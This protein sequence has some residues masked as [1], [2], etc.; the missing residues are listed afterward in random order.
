MKYKLA[1]TALALIASPS[2]F[3]QTCPDGVTYN[4]D[5]S[6][7]DSNTVTDGS[8]IFPVGGSGISNGS[9]AVC[10]HPGVQ[11]AGRIS[12]RFVGPITPT[13][14][15]ADYPSPAGDPN[16]DGRAAWNIEGHIDFG[17]AIGDG[18]TPPEMLGDVNLTV[19]VDCDPATD[20][21]DG[22]TLPLDLV[23]DT[24]V[25]LQFSQNIG[26]G[27]LCENYGAGFDPDA[28]GHYSFVLTLLEE[29][30]PSTTVLASLQ[31]NAIVGNP[32][33]APKISAVGIIESQQD[34]FKFPDGTVQTTA[35]V[36]GPPPAAFPST[37][38]VTVDNDV[39]APRVA[40]QFAACDAGDKII[41][42]GGRCRAGGF[43][44]DH[45]HKTCPANAAGA[46]LDNGGAD[47][48]TWAVQCDG[49]TSRAFAYAVCL[50]MTP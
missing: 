19:K 3:A 2:L 30:I 25:L 18:G 9:F 36:P 40:L 26:F 8:T 12:E 32:I 31:V 21:I 15:T 10:D 42:G 37:Y 43:F 27:F 45:M 20:I 28:D 6:V 44:G 1:L 13:P 47:F 23:P 39:P 50:D 4:T 24:A 33:M 16:N 35:A 11:I 38:I 48:Q 41:G 49:N 34:G 22:P 7:F 14:G 17:F 5:A 46:C 29:N